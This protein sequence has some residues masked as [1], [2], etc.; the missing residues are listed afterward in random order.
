MVF[1]SHISRRHNLKE[2][3]IFLP[4]TIFLPCLL[5]LYHK[6]R[7]RSFNYGCFFINAVVKHY[8]NMHLLCMM[9]QPL[10]INRS[11]V[12]VVSR[13][14]YFFR[15]ILQF[16]LLKPLCLL[17]HI[18][19]VFEKK[20]IYDLMLQDFYSWVFFF[21]FWSV[22][23]AICLMKQLL[24]WGT[25]FYAMICSYSNISLGMILLP[26][27]FRKIILIGFLQ[28]PWT[29]A[30]QVLGPFRLARYLVYN[31]VGL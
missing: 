16:W 27:S 7:F 31:V 5:L 25:N 19:E 1:F 23:I 20:S 26:W 3:S 14:A 22:L 6:K 21:G 13:R 2:N 8:W 28:R 29:F 15:V 24:R 17:F 30:T 18:N 4:F 11:I 9:S 10:W 12:S